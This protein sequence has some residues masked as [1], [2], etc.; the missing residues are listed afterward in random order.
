[1][2][3]RR[4][5]SVGGASFKRYQVGAT[6]PTRFE[7][8]PQLKVEGKIIILAA[9]SGVTLGTKCVD[10]ENVEKNFQCCFTDGGTY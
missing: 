9:P 1:M 8:R 6:L 3:P 4:G 10:W 2:L 5:S 7:S